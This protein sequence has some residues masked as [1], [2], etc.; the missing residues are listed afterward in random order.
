MPDL[1]TQITEVLLEHQLGGF[2]QD[3][4]STQMIAQCFCGHPLG[5]FPYAG[6]AAH[7]AKMLA[8]LKLEVQAEALREAAKTYPTYTRDM[9]SRAAVGDWLRAR[10][11]KLGTL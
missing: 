1:E 6:A 2:V 3:T 7:Q 10:A 4:M 9:V 8:P 5:E 11:D